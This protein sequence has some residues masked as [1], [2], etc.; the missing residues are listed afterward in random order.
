METTPNNW[1][2]DHILY[3]SAPKVDLSKLVVHK[4]GDFTIPP[5]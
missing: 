5:Y 2:P 1:R 4:F 3:K